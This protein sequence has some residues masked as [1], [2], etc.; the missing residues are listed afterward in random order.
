MRERAVGAGCFASCWVSPYHRIFE[1]FQDIETPA[2]ENRAS[3][4]HLFSGTSAKGVIVLLYH[5][6]LAGVK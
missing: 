4:V 3:R 6:S 2:I 1:A 5:F